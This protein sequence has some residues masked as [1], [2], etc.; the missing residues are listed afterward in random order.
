MDNLEE[1]LCEKKIL[2]SKLYVLNDL[3]YNTCVH[4][5]EKDYIENPYTEEITKIIYC[6]NCEMQQRR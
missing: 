4:K 2:E 3:I 5:W 6:N 1:L